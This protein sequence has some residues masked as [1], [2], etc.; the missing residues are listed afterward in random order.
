MIQDRLN[1]QSPHRRLPNEE[2]KMAA[3]RRQARQVAEGDPSR[4]P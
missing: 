4:T 3:V 1:Q 2:E